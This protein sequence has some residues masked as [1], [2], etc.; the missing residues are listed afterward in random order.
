MLEDTLEPKLALH[1]LSLLGD[2]EREGRGYGTRR[3]MTLLTD[4]SKRRMLYDVDTS[5]LKAAGLVETLPRV[6]F[7]TK[8]NVLLIYTLIHSACRPAAQPDL[9]RCLMYI[10]P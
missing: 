10:L 3:I 5:P 2:A 7:A 4:A 6:E 9:N 1:M 8:E